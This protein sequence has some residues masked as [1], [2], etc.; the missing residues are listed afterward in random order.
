LKISIQN[1][2]QFDASGTSIKLPFP[3]G[4]GLYI[5]KECFREINQPDCNKIFQ[6]AKN[7][8]KM[9]CGKVKLL[10]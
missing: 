7:V 6:K 3:D 1:N 2:N 4:I 5:V 8:K 9:S 10:I